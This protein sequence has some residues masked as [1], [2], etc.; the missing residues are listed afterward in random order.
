MFF[1]KDPFLTVLKAMVTMQGALK[2]K[3]QALNIWLFITPRPSPAGSL[4]DLLPA[5]SIM[6]SLHI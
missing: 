2:S 1:L 6:K 3:K 4:L 5:K